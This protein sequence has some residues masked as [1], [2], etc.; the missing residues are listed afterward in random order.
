MEQNKL[1][2]LIDKERREQRKELRAALIFC[3]IL[4]AIFGVGSFIT[5][6][7]KTGAI[8]TVIIT[9]MYFSLRFGIRFL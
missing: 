5:H 3:S 6:G 9:V 4:F 8:V 7:S 1:A 2:K